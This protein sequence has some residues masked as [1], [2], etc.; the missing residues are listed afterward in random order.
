MCKLKRKSDSARLKLAAVLQE[1]LLLVENPSLDQVKEAAA[2]AIKVDAGTALLAVRACMYRGKLNEYVSA[3]SL[4][5]ARS[6]MLACKQWQVEIRIVSND[7]LSRGP[8]PTEREV[9]HGAIRQNVCSFMWNDD[10]SKSTKSS[11]I[12]TSGL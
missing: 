4:L 10:K 11:L 5:S 7:S 1:T 3:G 12:F 8:P 2:A 9:I 6:F